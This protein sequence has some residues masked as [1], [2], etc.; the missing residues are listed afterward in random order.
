VLVGVILRSPYPHAEIVA[1]DISAAAAMDGVEAVITGDDL[2]D[3]TRYQ[4]SGPAHADRPV[5][6][7]E[8]V[9]FVGQEVAAVA[10]CDQP[11][12]LRALEAIAVTY[13]PRGAPLT[14]QQALKPGAEVLHSR[15]AGPNLAEDTSGAWGDVEAGRRMSA[16]TVEGTFKY[17]RATHV[18]MERSTTLANWAGHTLELW[19]TTQAPYYVAIEVAHTLGIDP[20][21]VICHDISVGGGFGARSKIAE[22]EVIAALLARRSGQPVRIELTREEEF[23]TTKTRHR[24]TVTTRMHA[25]SEGHICLIEGDLLYE[26]GAYNHSGP[27]VLKVG[28]KT[29][30]SLYRPDAVTWRARLVDTAVQPGGQ[31]RGYGGPQVAFALES[32]VD[33]LA[34]LLSVDPIDLRIA[35]A[36]AEGSTALC[37]ARIGSN[38]LVECLE[39][40]R[41]ELDWTLRRGEGRRP[42]RGLGVAAGMHGSGSHVGPGTDESSASVEID[43]DG[44]VQARFGSL[45]A[46]TG[47]RTVC[48]Q[49]AATELGVAPSEVAVI[50]GHG[51]DIPHDAGAWSSRGTHMAGHAVGAAA[52]ELA[53]KLR[54]LA[55]AKLGGSADAV[56][57]A[58]GRAVSG[59]RSVELAELVRAS[60]TAAGGVLVAEATHHETRMEV[61]G[62]DN[63]TP[64]FSASY[65]FGAHGAEVEV[66]EST[67]RIRVVDY[68]AAHDVG[69]AINP[70]ATQGQII[71][72]V[73]MAL[74]A[75]LGEELIHEGGRPVNPA[76]LNYPLPRAA[77]V[78]DVRAVLVEGP[79][80]AGP[81][82][83]KSA[84]EL[85]V[86][87]VAAAVANAVHDAVGIRLRDLPF[88]PDKVLA[89]LDERDGR[90]TRV[91]PLWRRPQRWW[92]AGLR[93]LYPAGLHSLLDRYGTRLARRRPAPAVTDV[94]LPGDV[95]STLNELRGPGPATLVAG[96]TDL[97]LQRRQGLAS[98]VKLI[99]T[100]E[101]AELRRIE[102]TPTG[103]VCVGAGATLSQLISELGDEIPVIADAA[104]SIASEQVRNAATL[105]GNLAQ[106]KRCWF[107]RNGFDCYKRGG[108]TCPCYA[109]LGDHRFHHAIVDAHRCQAVTPSDL[110]TVLVALD[111]TVT[112][113][114]AAGRRDVPASGLYSGPGEID[115]ASGEML[116]AVTVGA[117]AIARVSTFR[118]LALWEGDFAMVSAAL[119]A[120]V[121]PD[122]RWH[123][124][125]IV[126]GAIA[127]TPC[128]MTAAERSLEGRAVD[129]AALRSA[130][131]GE[132][133]RVAHPLAGNAW[134][135]RASEGI[136]A[137][138]AERLLARAAV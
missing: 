63:P 59:E 21:D 100:S 88:T 66:D 78:P 74:G 104:G 124:V 112:L 120:A 95:D 89:A 111:A 84:G 20:Q 105:G 127:P 7:T 94:V 25:T 96:N 133:E 128:R 125:R 90:S 40:V 131:A 114:S 38:R 70:G 119:S 106:A 32:Q 14:P 10:A 27:T 47:Q 91:R 107:F 8:R 85:P 39:A 6:A 68:V 81:Y 75:V 36:V 67:G 29:M 52:R 80:E 61:F 79:E 108:P 134:K 122:D 46:G 2:D 37:G 51:P 17:P 136:A 24:S 19:T 87:P 93:A 15:S 62:A 45:D 77:D 73:V 69:R 113:R 33:E 28:I 126:L 42:A 16:V 116:A 82:D 11:T 44:R 50:M 9:R 109:V 71:G 41:S 129:A 60:E 49:V 34:G 57:L 43:E 55:A 4:H 123:D 48:A 35:N 115:F 1:I 130:V 58:D 3:G 92:I 132:L 31:F 64:N 97:S 135:I 98:P 121:A 30:G 13:R 86:Y 72:G 99:A 53:G 22:H 65:T 103:G 138:A 101:V 83:A 117:P 12:A 110:A 18:C 26:N 5:L 102:R 23:G 56:V 118:K 76:M 137:Q 54:D